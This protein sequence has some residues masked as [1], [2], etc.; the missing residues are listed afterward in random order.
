[1]GEKPE[2]TD[3]DSIRI[4]CLAKDSLICPYRHY[5]KQYFGYTGDIR[6]G[7]RHALREEVIQ[8][9]I[10]EY[11]LRHAQEYPDEA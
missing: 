8:M 2:I 3:A 6:C 11:H 1:M 7:K 10:D 5:L 4:H 9:E